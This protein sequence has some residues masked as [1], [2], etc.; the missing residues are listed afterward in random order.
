MNKSDQIIAI[1]Q[2]LGWKLRYQNRGGYPLLE[3]KPKGFYWEVWIPPKDWHSTKQGKLCYSS[4]SEPW[5]E[6]YPECLNACHEMEKLLN[7]TDLQNKYQSEILEIS[8]GDYERKDNQNVF[9]Q[10]TATASQRCEA[11]LKTIGKW[12]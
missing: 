7:T 1:A 2:Q 9:N 3:S 10:L 12:K 4:N 8:H 6:N 5:P 11:F